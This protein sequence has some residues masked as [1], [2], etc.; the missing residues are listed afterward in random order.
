M[1]TAPTAHK[2]S[3]KTPGLFLL[4]AACFTCFTL[5]QTPKPGCTFGALWC[6]TSSKLPWQQ[7]C[8]CC[9]RKGWVTQSKARQGGTALG[10]LSLAHQEQGQRKI[11]PCGVVQ[12][13]PDNQV[14]HAELHQCYCWKERKVL[15]KFQAP[16]TKIN[17]KQQQFFFPVD[18]SICQDIK[19]LAKYG[20][21]IFPPQKLTV[22]GIYI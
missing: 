7:S 4:K 2:I 16:L 11:Q 17:M 21:L 20:N 6:S 1:W 8:R 10:Q 15:L 3:A 14:T 9:Q 13:G 22:F 5:K 19:T 12:Q 18:T